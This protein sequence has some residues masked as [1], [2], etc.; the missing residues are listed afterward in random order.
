MQ[1]VLPVLFADVQDSDDIRVLEL[2]QRTAFAQEPP[3]L[4]LPWLEQDLERH[5]AVEVS[6]AGAVDNAHAASGD[7]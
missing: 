6:S 1:E 4:R 3:G 5:D 7:L 2:R